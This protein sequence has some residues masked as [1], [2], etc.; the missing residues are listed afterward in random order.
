MPKLKISKETGSCQKWG[1]FLF[2]FNWS[3]KCWSK[4]PSCEQRSFC[5]NTVVAI[6]KFC[7]EYKMQT[8]NFPVLQRSYCWATKQKLTETL[9]SI[10]KQ[11][12]GVK[13]KQEGQVP[14][15]KPFLTTLQKFVC[16]GCSEIAHV[17]QSLWRLM[18]LWVSPSVLPEIQLI[19]KINLFFNIF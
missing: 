19:A 3:S 7:T 6:W 15:I 16:G 2:S 11:V 17:G 4:L 9:C 14:K 5:L 18:G 8:L 10:L 1:I 12:W 13:G